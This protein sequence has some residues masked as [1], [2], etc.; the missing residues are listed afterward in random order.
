MYELFQTWWPLA[1]SWFLM[2]LELP[3][4]SA[5][6]AR[7]PE[8]ALHLAAY[9]GITLPIC[10]IIESPIIMLLSASTTLCRDEGSYLRVRRFM[11][12]TGFVLTSVHVLLACTP[13]YD[14]VV[15][16]L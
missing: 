8:P 9:G 11:M 4:V 12:W 1:I 7:L 14:V 2:A 10:F 13:L 6:V 16:G 15:G 3:S 5:V